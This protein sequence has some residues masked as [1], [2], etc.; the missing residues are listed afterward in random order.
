[1][2]RRKNKRNTRRGVKKPFEERRLRLDIVHVLVI[3]FSR[4]PEVGRRS[5]MSW[6]V[7]TRSSCFFDKTLLLSLRSHTCFWRAPGLFFAVMSLTTNHFRSQLFF[8]PQPGDN[9][10]EEHQMSVDVPFDIKRREKQGSEIV[11]W[12]L[13]TCRTAISP[14]VGK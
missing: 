10:R 7:H 11:F 5:Q 9:F 3:N 12:G 2:A 13:L 8:P 6:L 14:L 4:K 1:L